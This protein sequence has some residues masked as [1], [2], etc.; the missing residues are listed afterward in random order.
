MGLQDREETYVVI[1][2]RCRRVAVGW[3]LHRADVFSP[4]W[5]VHCL[6]EPDAILAQQD[7]WLD[8]GGEG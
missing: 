7:P 5:W 4:S 1:C 2:P 6:R 8:E 3:P